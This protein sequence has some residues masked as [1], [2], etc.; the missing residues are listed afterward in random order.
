M[1]KG[2]PNP[3]RAE[4]KRLCY[5]GAHLTILPSHQQLYLKPIHKNAVVNPIQP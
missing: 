1:Y 2:I 5:R 3:L 4:F